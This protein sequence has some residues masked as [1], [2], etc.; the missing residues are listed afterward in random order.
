MLNITTSQS[1]EIYKA[2]L[3]A[4]TEIQA[5]LNQPV[6]VLLTQPRVIIGNQYFN[7]WVEKLFQAIKN[8]T[9]YPV[10][11]IRSRSRER[12]LVIVRQCAYKLIYESHFKPSYKQVGR[13][14]HRDHST[15][16]HGINT[17]NNDLKNIDEVRNTMNLIKQALNNNL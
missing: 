14:F 11:E 17:V 15:I 4:E 6:K 12:G 1:G 8:S 3:R 7:E 5:I 2:L 13:F 16:I 9:G 10:H